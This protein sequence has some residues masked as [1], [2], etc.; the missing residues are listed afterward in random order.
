MQGLTETFLADG[1]PVPT[2]SDHRHYVGADSSPLPTTVYNQAVWP[3]KQTNG[4]LLPT[5]NNLLH[6]LYNFL[7][8]RDRQTSLPN[9]PAR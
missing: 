4:D 7:C 3:E 1:T 2:S 6:S 8:R 9:S 5:G